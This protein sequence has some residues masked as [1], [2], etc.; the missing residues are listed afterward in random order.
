MT[1]PSVTTWL[2]HLIHV[3]RPPWREDG[4]SL[5]RVIVST[6]MSVA[7]MYI[8]FTV[9]LLLRGITVCMQRTIYTRPCHILSSSRYSGSL[10]TWPS[11]SLSL[12]YLHDFIWR[13]FVAGIILLYNH[14]CTE[15]C[16]PCANHE[17][18]WALENCRW[19]R[20]PCFVGSEISLD[21]YLTQIPGRDRYKSL[22][23]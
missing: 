15:A 11:P 6:N 19:C 21:G 17:P 18:L 22:E 7:S 16:K 14:I 20:E 4:S 13:L 12:L 5:V 23:S 9:Y 3:R 1:R 8:I 2:C 10:V